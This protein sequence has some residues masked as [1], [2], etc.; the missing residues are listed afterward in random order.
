MG[1]TRNRAKNHHYIPQ[2]YL[3][4]FAIQYKGR[5]FPQLSVFDRIEGKTYKSGVDSVGC[6]NYFNRIKLDGMDHNAL[7]AAMSE[8]ETKLA[9]ALVRINQVR[10]LENEDDRAHLITLI[11]LTALRNPEMRENIRKIH[12]DVG[13]MNIAARLQSPATYDTSVQEAKRQGALPETYNV[14]FEEMKAAFE[15]GGFKLILE[16]NALVSLELQMLDHTMPLLL[17]RGW[18]LLRAPD[19]SG[20]FITSD[21]PFWLMWSNP[22][23]RTGPDAPGLAMT[24]T[25]IYFPISPQLA[26][27]GAFDVGNTIEDVDEAT[28]AVANSAMTASADRQVYAR[29]H[30]FSYARTREETARRGDQL[31]SDKRFTRKR[32]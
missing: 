32:A 25:D 21:Q 23:L 5:K 30:K 19:G 29:D 26:V 2:C 17:K 3:K 8:F 24:G 7:E 4:H 10:S 13:K 16:S 28:V 22:A 15:S 14:T 12:E 27:V 9:D 31:I 20:G 1:T 18:H 6:Q 11:G